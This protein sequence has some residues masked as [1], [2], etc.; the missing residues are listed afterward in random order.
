MGREPEPARRCG[1]NRLSVVGV[2]VTRLGQ[3]SRVG[4]LALCLL[5]LSEALAG[6]GQGTATSD[7]N[8]SGA[9]SAVKDHAI[10]SGAITR[11][12]HL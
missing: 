4:L 9:A 10:S 2:N 12:P 6:C 8:P 3:R 7:E 11:I 1:G 5:A